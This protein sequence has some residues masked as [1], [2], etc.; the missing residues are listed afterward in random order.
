[1]MPRQRGLAVPG[2]AD[3]ARTTERGPVSVK[4]LLRGRRRDEQVRA[5]ARR[6]RQVGYAGERGR[7]DVVQL[8]VP[9]GSS[10]GDAF[11]LGESVLGF[12]VALLPNPP[13]PEQPA[14]KSREAT[15]SYDPDGA[16]TLLEDAYEADNEDDD[17]A[18]MLHDDGGIGDERPEV[19]GLNPWVAL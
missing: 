15:P 14:E 11:R 19:V 12:P 5:R 17:R 18:D 4:I 7:A 8:G 13:V 9:I 2:T 16:D 3:V 10:A 6:R 1:M